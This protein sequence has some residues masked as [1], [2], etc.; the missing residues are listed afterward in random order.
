MKQPFKFSIQSLLSENKPGDISGPMSPT[1]FAKEMAQQ[2]EFTY[3]RLARV[4]FDDAETFQIY[5]D[6]E[7]L[8][9]HD[10][11]LIACQYPDELWLSLWVDSGIGGLPVAMAN[12]SDREITITPIYEKTE[13]ARKLTIQELQELFNHVF[14]NPQKIAIHPCKK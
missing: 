3:N 11:L 13:Y 14:D 2:M 8:T 1:L 4:W 6:G 9:G 12:Q 10:T 5:E 7:G